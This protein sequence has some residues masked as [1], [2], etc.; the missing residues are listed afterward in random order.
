MTSKLSM[1]T[2]MA[3]R[4]SLHGIHLDLQRTC[5]LIAS[6]HVDKTNRY[7]MFPNNRKQFHGNTIIYSKKRIP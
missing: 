1:A 3:T 6:I 4:S 7:R 5:R 2:N